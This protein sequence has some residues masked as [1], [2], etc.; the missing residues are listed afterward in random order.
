MVRNVYFD[1]GISASL[2]AVENSCGG[3]LVIIENLEAA[4]L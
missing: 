3:V 2:Q 1:L 4:S